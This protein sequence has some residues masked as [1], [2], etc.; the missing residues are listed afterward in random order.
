MDFELV[1]NAQHL[2]GE[3]ELFFFNNINIHIIFKMQFFHM[4]YTAPDSVHNAVDY[5]VLIVCNPCV[6]VL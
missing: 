1:E 3:R 6:C 5:L 4:R 2:I